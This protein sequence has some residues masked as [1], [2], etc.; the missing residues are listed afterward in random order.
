MPPISKE[1]DISQEAEIEY[2]R[3]LGGYYL[4]KY[5]RGDVRAWGAVKG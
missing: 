5:E 3:D 1:D 4:I 2:V